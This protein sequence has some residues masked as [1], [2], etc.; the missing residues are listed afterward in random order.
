MAT[1]AVK[2]KVFFALKLAVGVGLVFYVLRSGMIDFQALHEVLRN[3]VNLIVSFLFLAFSLFCCGTR[4]YLLT[5]AQG[6]NLSYKA[7]IEL[8]MIGNFF[9][10]FMPGAVGGDLIKAWY[11]AGAAPKQ[12]TKSVFTVLLDRIIGLSVI[13]FY[14]A[15][16]LLFY[17]TWM[18]EHR[19]L[20][21]LAVG[22]WAFTFGSLF[23]ALLFF[24]SKD[25]RWGFSKR[26]SKLVAR[27]QKLSILFDAIL[28]YRSKH[29]TV[30][31]S[32]GLSALSI[33]GTILL[34]RIQGNTIGITLDTAHYFFIVP[35]GLTVSAIP[36]LPGGIGVGQVAFFS[37]FQWTGASNPEQGATLCTLMQV[38]TIL[39]N[40]VGAIF[41]LKYK[42][43]PAA[44][45]LPL[46]PPATAKRRV[47]PGI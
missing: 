3:P 30:L 7:L 44:S 26:F 40:C 9:N 45:D 37:L 28:L 14:A 2:D 10:T 19:E 29:F 23:F 8:T 6:L 33:L 24:S 43:G 41:Y 21:G 42:R 32:V 5:K 22:I 36:L 39:F 34:F 12:K 15:M 11:V 25:G 20:Q 31:A 4:W 1:K 47:S 16:T 27:S 13:V 46:D 38:Y 18:K 17:S 35:I